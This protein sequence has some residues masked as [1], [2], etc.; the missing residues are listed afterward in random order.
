M[1]HTEIIDYTIAFV[2][3]CFG[4]SMLCIVFAVFFQGK[5]L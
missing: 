2:F 4:I 5:D 3:V 1:T